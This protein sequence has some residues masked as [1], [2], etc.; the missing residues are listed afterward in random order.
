MRRLHL[1]GL[2]VLLTACTDTTA[3][4]STPITCAAPLVV[5]DSFVQ[6]TREWRLID[7]QLLPFNI[8][9]VV[10]QNRLTQP[11]R[12][13][14]TLAFASL[15]IFKRGGRCHTLFDSLLYRS[16]P[17]IVRALGRTE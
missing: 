3:P 5:P 15:V 10:V 2:A 12:Q 1:L 16:M 14:D 17:P 4:Q 11:P 9:S 6:Y 7:G 13:A 8:D